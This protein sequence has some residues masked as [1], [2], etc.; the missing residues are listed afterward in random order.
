[1]G[2]LPHELVSELIVPELRGLLAHKL[3][4]KGFGQLRISKFLG[5]SQP[6]VSKYMS[7]GPPEYLKRLES[8]GLDT[9]EVMRTVEIL[10]EKVANENYHGYL[11]LMS[12]FLNSLLRRGLLCETHKKISPNVPR[13]CEV[14][15]KL[16]EEVSD[17]YV[18]EVKVAYEILS[19]HPKGYE[20]VPEVGMNI[21]SAPPNAKDFRD[22]AG[23]SGRIVRSNNKVVA[24]GEP[25]KGGS[26]HTASILLKIMSKFPNIRAAVVIKYDD[27]CISRLSSAGLNVVNTGPHQ[28]IN[29]FFTSLER[30]VSEL[31]KEPDAVA[32]AGGLGIEPVIYVFSLSAINAVKKA[33][34]CV[35]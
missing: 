8:L 28:S 6:M 17:P 10:V 13:D 12:G 31:S 35:E 11:E 14:C 5:I 26:K 15:F 4:E 33:L 21:V 3:S 2:L 25:V 19:F 29:A 30:V 7:I 1:M 18:E 22:V 9:N 20:I 24:V 32:D 16:F 34:M 27:K 23:F